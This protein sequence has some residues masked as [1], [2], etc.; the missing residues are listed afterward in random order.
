MKVTAEQA[1]RKFLNHFWCLDEECVVFLIFDEIIINEIKRKMDD[2][3]LQKDILLQAYTLYETEVTEGEKTNK[4]FIIN[5][6]LEN[7]RF[8]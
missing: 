2:K 8:I 1:V 7:F 3:L 4:L 5:H 6:E